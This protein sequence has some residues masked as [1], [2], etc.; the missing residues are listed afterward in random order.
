[1]TDRHMDDVKPIATTVITAG[2]ATRH[3]HEL[4]VRGDMVIWLAK[5]L[6]DGDN[7][8]ASASWYI[9]EARERAEA[10]D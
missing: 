5:Q 7:E 8:G 10:L 9:R 2:D 3:K 6:R 4:R 1:M